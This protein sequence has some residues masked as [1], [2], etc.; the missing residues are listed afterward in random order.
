MSNA[1]QGTNGAE[2]TRESVDTPMESPEKLGKGKG[3][4]AEEMPGASDEEDDDE[5]E[6]SIAEG[7]VEEPDEDNMEEI[8]PDNIVGSR[9]RGKNIDYAEAAKKL[10]AEQGDED[11]DDDE[12][13]ED[14]DDKMHD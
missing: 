5:E 7:D 3:K 13:F 8:D 1:V 11:D 2:A 10:E 12:D 4:M 6:V 9:T 14:E